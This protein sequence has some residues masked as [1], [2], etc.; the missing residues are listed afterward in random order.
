MSRAHA[1]LAALA[2]TA[3][4]NSA[5]I[6]GTC[7]V[8]G[9]RGVLLVGR[10][11]AGKSSLA[12]ALIHDERRFGCLVADDRVLLQHAHGRWIASAPDALRGRFALRGGPIEETDFVDRAV[13]DLVVALDETGPEEALSIRSGDALAIARIDRALATLGGLGAVGTGD[14]PGGP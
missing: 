13:V 1:A 6:H 7:V 5:G 2:E 3:R 8:R 14:T 11:G 10:G 12:L 9:E 4:G